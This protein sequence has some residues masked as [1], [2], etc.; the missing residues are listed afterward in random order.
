MELFFQDMN[1][2][3]ISRKGYCLVITRRRRLL[4]FFFKFKID[5][6][7]GNVFTFILTL[8]YYI[9]IYTIITQIS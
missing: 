5:D 6:A 3:P 2:K 8:W 9:L 1:G 4:P 7:P